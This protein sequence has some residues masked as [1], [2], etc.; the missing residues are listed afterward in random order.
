MVDQQNQ[1]MQHMPLAGGQAT[2]I[3]SKE[4]AA[5]YRSK[6]EIYNFLAT[7]VGIYL[8]PKYN[9]T[10][11]FLKELMGGQKKMLRTT[12]IRTIHIPQ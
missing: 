2:R 4:L 10:I 3:S 12:K 11:F 6:N 5:K 1:Q 7:D 8:P 9:V